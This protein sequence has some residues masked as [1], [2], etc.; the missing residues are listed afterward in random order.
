MVDTA[1]TT[2]AS[3]QPP[4]IDCPQGT[5][6]KATNP[7]MATGTR[8]TDGGTPTTR[9]RKPYPGLPGLTHMGHASPPYLPMGH[10]SPPAYPYAPPAYP[11]AQQQPPRNKPI[12]SVRSNPLLAQFP[13]LARLDQE[14]R[15]VSTAPPSYEQYTTVGTIRCMDKVA[16]ATLSMHRIVPTVVYC[17]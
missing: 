16:M 14:Q 12:P 9:T 11:Y 10:A 13:D 5:P 2:T 1:A 8:H 15:G 6:T 4:T 3:P 7:T 17:S